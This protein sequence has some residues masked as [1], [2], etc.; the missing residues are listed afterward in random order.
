MN[1]K[2][3]SPNTASTVICRKQQNNQLNEIVKHT[4]TKI[5]N[6]RSG[7]TI[8]TVSTKLKHGK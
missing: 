8:E 2:T 6:Q 4:E 1:S 7:T 5:T 3:S